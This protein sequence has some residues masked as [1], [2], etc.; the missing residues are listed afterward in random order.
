[1][2]RSKMPCSSREVTEPSPFTSTITPPC[3]SPRALT[4]SSVMRLM[5]SGGGVASMVVARSPWMPTP[6]S[7]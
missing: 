6:N 1:M 7:T 3:K 4:K 5:T 2:Q